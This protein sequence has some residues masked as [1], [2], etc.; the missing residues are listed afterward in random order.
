MDTIS[1]MPYPTNSLPPKDRITVD[2]PPDWAK[3]VTVCFRCRGGHTLSGMDSRLRGNDGG[4]ESGSPCTSS[5]LGVRKADDRLRRIYSPS[6]IVSGRTLV[7]SPTSRIH[8]VSHWPGRCKETITRRSP[9]YRL[10][11]TSLA[12][13]KP[14]SRRVAGPCNPFFVLTGRSPS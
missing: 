13:V 12:F 7:Q 1:T 14:G 10:S 4:W 9:A 5:P 8:P 2:S 6:S 3:G 11:H